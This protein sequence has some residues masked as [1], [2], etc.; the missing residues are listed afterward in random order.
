M[1][2]LIQFDAFVLVAIVLVLFEMGK[3]VKIVSV[4]IKGNV[5]SLTLK[6]NYILQS[7]DAVLLLLFD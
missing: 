4:W 3:S 7:S 2:L 6:A 1:N 5:L